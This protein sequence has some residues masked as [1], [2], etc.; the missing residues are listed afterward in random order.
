M[1]NCKFSASFGE[2]WKK[3][4][5]WFSRHNGLSRLRKKK[6]YKILLLN[7]H[8]SEASGAEAT[9]YELHCVTVAADEAWK[10]KHT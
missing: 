8:R 6:E 3:D 2:I 1:K 9:N 5:I 4:E 7:F 10:A